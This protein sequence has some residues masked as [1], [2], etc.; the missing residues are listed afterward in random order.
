MS[1][2]FWSVSASPETNN[3]ISL[4]ESVLKVFAYSYIFFIYNEI[5]Q[6]VTCIGAVQKMLPEACNFINRNKI[7]LLMKMQTAKSCSCCTWMRR[8]L[9]KPSNCAIHV[10]DPFIMDCKGKGEDTK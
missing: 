1:V 7:K 5:M 2:F 8:M 4:H 3:N 9:S 6:Q 10:L